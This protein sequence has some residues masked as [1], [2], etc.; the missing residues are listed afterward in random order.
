MKKALITGI[1][2]QDGSY[3]AEF[4]LSKGYEVHGIIRRAS[5]FNT[6]RIDHIYLDPIEHPES[7]LLLHYGDLSD[8]GIL[9][10]LI[11][12]IQPE[13]IYHLGAQSHVR[14][15]FD[16]P[17][18]TGNV[19]GLGTTRLLESIRRSGI[20]TKFYQASSSE[21]FGLA[22]PPQNETTPMIPQSPY[23][24]AKLYSY[25]MVINYRKAYNVFASNG[26]LFNH[27]SPR[28]GEIFVTRKI[29]RGISAILSGRQRKLFLGNLDARRDWG[30]APEY[31]QLMWKILQLDNPDDFVIGTGESHS[32]REFVENALNYCNIEIEWIGKGI[33]EKGI[34]KSFDQNWQG[35]LETGQ[36]IIEIKP[37]FFRPTEVNFLMADCNKARNLLDWDPKILFVDLVKI[38]MDFDLLEAGLKPKFEGFAIAKKKGLNWTEHKFA[39]LEMIQNEV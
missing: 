20:K 23:A 8:S 37:R 7:R 5:T 9:N 24:I 31:V 32:V 22:S 13:E 10:E 4:L 35:I 27:E 36:T 26:I 38:M 6:H 2:G 25:W 18:Y 39:H 12:N 14:L 33:D 1:T 34:V 30:F 29:T 17:E 28:R 3:L 15:S 21:L 11:Y 16:L 19:T